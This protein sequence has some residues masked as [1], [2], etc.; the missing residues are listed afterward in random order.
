[1]RNF[2]SFRTQHVC[3]M[4]DSSVLRTYS[5]YHQKMR[6]VTFVCSFVMRTSS[7]PT[8]TFVT[9]TGGLSLLRYIYKNTLVQLVMTPMMRMVVN[10]E[11][12]EDDDN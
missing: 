5:L 11:E 6:N 12:E 3:Q 9:N 8:I 2:S 10:D 4:S 1:M 7:S